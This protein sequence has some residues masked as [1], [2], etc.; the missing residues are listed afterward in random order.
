MRV[1]KETQLAFS[2]ER[3]A[4]LRNDERLLDL[5]RLGRVTNALAFAYPALTR[6]IRHQTPRTRRDRTAALY[7]VGA[8]AFEGL[9]VSQGLAR[10]YRGFPQ[11]QAGLGK[12]NT[13]PAV[14]A[15]ATKFLKP[16]RD[17]VAFHF[18]RDVYSTA[19]RGIEFE[20][21]RVA[22]FNTPNA[23][24]VYFDFVDDA[25][26]VFLTGARSNVEHLHTL[27][28]FMVGTA[29][30][31]N[32]LLRGAHRLLPAAFRQMGAV[33]GRYVRVEPDAV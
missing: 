14:T 12:L 19:I 21:Y 17:K 13:D 33:P 11:F 25:I 27:E 22:T 23:A 3:W 18:D 2:P 10:H 5:L 26:G 24:G 32:R 20:E 9:Q 29:S 28:Q 31:A 30:V 15:L 8:V 4:T 16:L 1:R 7:Y 6:D